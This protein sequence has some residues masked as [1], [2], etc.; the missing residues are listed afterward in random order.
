LKKFNISI[1]VIMVILILVVF[2]SGCVSSNNNTTNS[3]SSSSSQSGQ[4]ASSTGNPAIKISAS[5]AWTG[6]IAD[7]AGSKSVDGSGYQTIPLPLNPGSVTVTFQK[8]N[9]K[10]VIVNGTIMPDTS[11]L[12]VQLVDKDGNI[13]AAQ[14]TSADAGVVTVSHTF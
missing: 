2:A 8:D 5:G 12:T 3:S 9:S 7:N 13:V 4:S 6:N 14:S 1:L 10:D 11:T